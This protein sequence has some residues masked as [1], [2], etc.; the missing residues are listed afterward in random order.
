M[1]VILKHLKRWSTHNRKK[2]IKQC[3]SSHLSPSDW[4]KFKFNN[5]CIGHEETVTVI[6]S[7][8]NRK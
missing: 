2:Q 5:I 6:Y 8:K 1:K 7:D 4:Q 3:L